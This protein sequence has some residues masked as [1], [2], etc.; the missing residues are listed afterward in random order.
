MIDWP[1]VATFVGAWAVIWLGLSLL[2]QAVLLACD[3]WQ[4]RRN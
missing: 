2:W 1:A 4:S 3:R